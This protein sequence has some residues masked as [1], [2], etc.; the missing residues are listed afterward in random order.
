MKTKIDKSKSRNKSSSSFFNSKNNSGFFSVQPKLKVGQP[1]DKYEVEADRV[2]DEVVNYQSENQPFFAP[3]LTQSIQKKPNKFIQEKPIAERITPLVQRQEEE[4]EEMQPKLLD[5]AVQRQEEEE[6]FLQKQP[7]EEEEEMLQPKSA[8][9]LRDT[10]SATEQLLNTSKQNGSPLNSEVRSKME[11]S[12]G[13]DFRGV[14]IHTDNTAVQLNKDLGAQAFTSGNN[15]YFNDGKYDPQTNNGKKLL[16]HELTH[17]VQQGAAQV[18]PFIQ[19]EIIAT[20]SPATEKAIEGNN[21][22]CDETTQ[23]AKQLFLNHGIYGP[24]STTLEYGGFESTYYPLSEILDV[25]VRGKT[26][27]VN[28]L[29][30]D[31]TGLVTPENEDLNDLATILNYINDDVLTNTVISNYYTWSEEQKITSRINFKKRI[32]ES[33]K[34]WE[35]GGKIAFNVDEQ[36]WEDI[37]ANVNININVQDEGDA[38]FKDSK[39][40]KSDHIQVKLVKNPERSENDEIQKLISE[41]A[42]KVG[43]ARNESI[44]TSADLTTTANVAFDNTMTLT[45]FDLQDSPNEKGSSR[46]SMLRE[47]VYFEN[48]IA[49]LDED[50]VDALTAFV[51]TFKNGDNIKSNNKVVLYGYAS[52]PGST[53]YNT[54]LVNKRLDSVYNFLVNNGI[55]NIKSQNKQINYSDLE[56]EKHD[57]RYS[58]WFRRVE[59]VVGSG[60]LQNTVTHELGHVFKLEDEYVTPKGEDGSG[61]PRGELVGHNKMAE[62]IGVGD[63]MGNRLI[64]IL[65]EWAKSVLRTGTGEGVRAEDSDNIMSMGNEVRKQHYGPFGKSLSKLTGKV[66]RVF[67]KK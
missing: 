43:D 5:A 53:D 36:C 16:A 15:I 3:S 46:R 1:D 34:L 61:E 42:K 14:K 65:P 2:A 55:T 32:E 31:S 59:L 67:N 17:T 30:A 26:K 47:Q 41:T 22:T 49:D 28:G 60:E 51:S 21:E 40:S 27:F 25:K 33:T 57:K 9:Q 52:K 23:K 10:H 7:I 66:W 19:R 45:N 48:N 24:Q 38:K 11:G 62:D 44:D 13:T 64:R 58:A 6:E 18:Q 20:T 54:N 50:A 4:E 63:V 8:S 39:K 56:A 37:E 29:E 35:A 12:F